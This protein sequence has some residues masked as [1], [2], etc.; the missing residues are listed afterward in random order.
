VVAET[1]PARLDV[2]VE[3]IEPAP[4]LFGYLWK[5]DVASGPVWNATSLGLEFGVT[6]PAEGEYVFQAV[7]EDDTL[8]TL[9]LRVTAVSLGNLRGAGL[10]PED[11]SGGQGILLR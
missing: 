2:F 10:L 3:E 9:P 7:S 1:F 5:K 11:L 8:I 6:I 4:L